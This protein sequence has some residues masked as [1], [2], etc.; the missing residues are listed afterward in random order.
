MKAKSL[1]KLVMSAMRSNSKLQNGQEKDCGMKWASER[2]SLLTSQCFSMT[3]FFSLVVQW[4]YIRS[5]M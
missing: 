2:E 4:G 1:S 5:K 3:P